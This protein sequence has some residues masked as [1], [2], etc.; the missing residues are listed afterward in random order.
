M[1][2]I[3]SDKIIAGVDPKLGARLSHLSYGPDSA[4]LLYNHC[5]EE[6][7]NTWHHGGIPLLFPFAGRVYDQGARGQYRA[8]G[9]CFKMPIH[10][11]VH[12]QPF[13]V[14]KHQQNSVT[15][16]FLDNETTNAIYPWRFRLTMAWTVSDDSVKWKVH[17][18]NRG[19]LLPE[20]TDM[21]FSLGLHPYFATYDLPFLTLQTHAIKKQEVTKEGLGGEITSLETPVIDVKNPEFHNLIL[22]DFI[23]PTTILANHRYTIRMY[24]PKSKVYVLWSSNIDQFFCLEPWMGLPDAIHNHYGLYRLPL[25][26]GFTW[27]G[28]L[29]FTAT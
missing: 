12:N 5:F 17:V 16:Q 19:C 29:S 6:S 7:V 20:K 26:E 27:E 28:R 25:S 15:L 22:R 3:K 10:G 9:Q 2:E 4:N 13:K 24:S 23:D 14:I 1:I 18:Q 8:G 11:F 21:P